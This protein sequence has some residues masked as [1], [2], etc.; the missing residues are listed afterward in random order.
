L[1][2]GNRLVVVL[3]APQ[4]RGDG[5]A[6]YTALVVCKQ[7][8][9]DALLEFVRLRKATFEYP[10]EAAE[11]VVRW[12]GAQQMRADTA[13]HQDQKPIARLAWNQ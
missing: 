9:R 4:H 11:R 1:S 13:R 3:L 12:C 2:G 8:Q 10:L 7:L 6:V 5:L